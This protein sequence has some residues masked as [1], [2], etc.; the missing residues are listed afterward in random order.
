MDSLLLPTPQSSEDLIKSI[1]T[2]HEPLQSSIQQ[3]ELLQSTLTSRIHSLASNYHSNIISHQSSLQNLDPQIKVLLKK[4]ENLNQKTSKLGQDLETSLEKMTDGI[5][6][7]EK[8]QKASEIVKNLQ[9]FCMKT[10]KNRIHDQKEIQELALQLSGI[11]IVSKLQG[12]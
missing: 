3:L 10:K 9:Q 8:V 4:S 1:L 12:K 11:N 5:E 7:L 6:K 2:S